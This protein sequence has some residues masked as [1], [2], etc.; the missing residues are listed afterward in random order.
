MVNLDIIQTQNFAQRD[1]FKRISQRELIP[2]AIKER[3]LLT[4]KIFLF[5]PISTFASVLT[6]SNGEDNQITIT[7][8]HN[9]KFDLYVPEIYTSI[10]VNSSIEDTNF[11]LPGGSSITES[12]WIWTPFSWNYDQY[13]N[14]QFKGRFRSTGKIYIRNVSAGASQNI[15]L[16]L[17]TKYVAGTPA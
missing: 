3:H 4:G 7:V 12:Q 11:E 15:T 6:L 8:S 10:Y 1:R 13:K 16:V 9:E 17:Q 5:G 2:T 14:A